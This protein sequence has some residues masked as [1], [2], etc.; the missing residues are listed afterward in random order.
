MVIYGMR[1]YPEEPLIKSGRED[2][3]SASTSVIGGCA[4]LIHP[5]IVN[6]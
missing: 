1:K 2:K 4:V 3:R 6:N 5:T